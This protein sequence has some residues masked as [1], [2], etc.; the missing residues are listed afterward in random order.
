MSGV[1]PGFTGGSSCWRPWVGSKNRHDSLA[2]LQHWMVIAGT[3][4][5]CLIALVIFRFAPDPALHH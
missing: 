4:V 1:L 2:L 3:T 5:A